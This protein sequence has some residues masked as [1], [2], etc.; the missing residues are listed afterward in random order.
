MTD[1]AIRRVELQ[2]I[3]IQEFLARL[4]ASGA[5][6]AIVPVHENEVRYVLV[7]TSSISIGGD[8]VS[9]ATE[10]LDTRCDETD[11]FL[12]CRGSTAAE[13]EDMHKTTVAGIQHYFAL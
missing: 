12:I 2:S 1:L 4:D 6:P 9:Y 11:W 10:A 13:A 8:I 5:A 7:R 3:N